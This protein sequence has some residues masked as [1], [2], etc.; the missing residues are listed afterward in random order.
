MPF[1][2]S[3]LAAGALAIA[4]LLPVPAVAEQPT[5][6]PEEEIDEGLKSLVYLA[7]LACG[8][9]TNEQETDLEREVRK[10]KREIRGALRDD[11]APRRPPWDTLCGR[12]I[13]EMAPAG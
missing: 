9:V 4:A 8:C 2:Y 7:A 1:P 5:H 3:V 11:A 6:D 13:R 10:E 12:G